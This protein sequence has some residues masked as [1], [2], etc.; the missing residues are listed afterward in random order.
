MSSPAVQNDIRI[1]QFCSGAICEEI[2][3]RLRINLAGEPDRLPRHMM[4][5]VEQMAQDDC[6][7]AVLAEFVQTDQPVMLRL[8][9]NA[10]VTK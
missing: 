3:D 2:G 10:E 5:P 7:S 8:N 9:Q 1:D 4:T 6:V